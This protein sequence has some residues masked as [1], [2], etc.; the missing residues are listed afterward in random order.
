[1]AAE[2]GGIADAGAGVDGVVGFAEAAAEEG[3]GASS[4]SSSQLKSSS[5]SVSVVPGI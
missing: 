1:M 3:A 5:F 2:V 4:S